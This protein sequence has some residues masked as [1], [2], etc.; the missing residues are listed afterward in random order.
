VSGQFA[1]LAFD[2]RG[3]I[4]RL[5]LQRAAQGNAIN[6]QMAHELRRVAVLCAASTSLRVLVLGGA[7][8]HFC[9]GGDLRESAATAMPAAE[10]S[11]EITRVLH[12]AML[13]LVALPAPC[14]IALRG[15]AAGA[16]MGLA[17]IGDLVVATRSAKLVPAYTKVSLTPD[18]GVS[19][20]LPRLVGRAR[21]MEMLLLNREVRA[22]E[23]L[24]WGLVNRVVDDDAL[25]P[26]VDEWAGA[27]ARGPAGAFAATRAL[28]RT[29]LEGL[30]A[31]M[32]AES[33]CMA[34]QAASPEGATGIAAFMAT[35][36]RRD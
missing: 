30:A 33:L 23:A 10:Y 34:R 3:G 14:V 36:R 25:D 28:V 16:G 31:Q 35:S 19:F 20:L 2:E 22:E 7:G 17:L 26:A 15:V 12:E 18:A 24:Q 11:R 5:T 29:S 27:L 1:T 32:E 9:L 6:L 21:T 13:A 4:G 8:S